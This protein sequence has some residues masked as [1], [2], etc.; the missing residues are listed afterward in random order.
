MH[1]A[2]SNLTQSPYHLRASA[3]SHTLG[4]ES[5]RTRM[6]LR[7]G[8]QL[9]TVESHQLPTP[10]LSLSYLV[11]PASV[12]HA[13]YNRLVTCSRRW[14]CERPE[15][16]CPPDSQE[17]NRPVQK[18]TMRRLS[19]LPAATHERY[20]QARGAARREQPNHAQAQDSNIAMT[21]KPRRESND[22]S[23][24]NPNIQYT[25]ATPNIS[26][27]TVSTNG[28]GTDTIAP[29]PRGLD[30]MRGTSTLPG[31]MVV[32]EPTPSPLGGTSPFTIP[33]K[34]EHDPEGQ[35]LD[36]YFTWIDPT[37]ME[38]EKHHEKDAD[39]AQT[40]FSVPDYKCTTTEG[41]YETEKEAQLEFDEQG[42]TAQ[43]RLNDQFY[44]TET[45]HDTRERPSPPISGHQ[46]GK[47]RRSTTSTQKKRKILRRSSSQ[48]DEP[49]PDI[50]R[51]DTKTSTN[52]FY[53]PGV[54]KTNTKA[55]LDA[56]FIPDDGWGKHTHPSPD[57]HAYNVPAVN[58]KDT[59][60][61]PA[62][63]NASDPRLRRNRL[64]T[65]YSSDSSC[66]RQGRGSL[67]RWV[68]YDRRRK[69]IKFAA[70]E[71]DSA[72]AERL[73]LL[74]KAKTGKKEVSGLVPVEVEEKVEE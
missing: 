18:P 36:N 33:E 4:L 9:C 65:T 23:L 53:T 12:M 59:D 19:C 22:G 47:S 6:V 68:R 67:G 71:F 42:R 38:D 20:V 41:E 46:R 62:G 49:R 57:E 48:T 29:V 43:D 39:E 72:L 70:G 30:Q 10:L 60:K 56:W 25:L 69:S 74:T 63:P 24:E 61:Q 40:R 11:V 3:T 52:V 13:S 16:Y 32:L 34:R 35:Q 7:T 26:S 5:F 31:H 64:D 1:A 55:S 27:K 73:R 44:G 50:S 8:A 66:S 17:P 37:L 14:C 2:P 58:N 45:G 51:S 54:S 28:G 15:I 21:S